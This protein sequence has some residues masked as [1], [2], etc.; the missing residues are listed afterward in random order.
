MNAL[1]VIDVQQGFDEYAKRFG[2]RNNEDAET[3]IAEVIAAYRHH[4]RPVIHIHHASKEQDSPLRADHRGYQVKPEA[5]PLESEI[6]FV[7]H[8]NSAF[9]GTNLETYLRE[10]GVS[11]VT[12]IGATTDHC[13][14]TTARMAANLGFEVLYISDALWTL[15]KFMPDGTRVPAQLVHDVNIASLN[16]EFAKILTTDAL[17]KRIGGSMK[18]VFFPLWMGAGQQT[19]VPEGARALRQALGGDALEIAVPETANLAKTD[20]IKAKPELL[21]AFKNATDLLQGLERVA[22]LGGD[23]S[24]DYPLLAHSSQLYGQNLAVI[25]LDTHG[26][27]NTAVSS[28]SGHFHGQVLRAN[29]GE[30]DADLLALNPHPLEPHQV[31]FGGARDF[32]PPEAQYIQE[33][34]IHVSSIEA[35]QRDPTSL[36]RAVKNTGFSKVHVHLDL[37]VLSAAEFKSSPFADDAGLKINELKAVIQAIQEQLEIVSFAITEYSPKQDGDDLETVIALIHA[38]EG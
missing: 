8:V 4:K 25:W 26:D 36:A 34:S 29:L 19:R 12:I 23:C 2:G 22:F 16:G 30:G 3:R 35:L 28:P 20:G 5:A 9:I 11:S 7:K 27:L 24:S 33:H 15:D 18:R 21:E 38:L 32:D 14:S 17:I 1:L 6:I 13:C 31:F 37:D 10:Q